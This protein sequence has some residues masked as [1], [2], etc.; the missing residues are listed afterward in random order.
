MYTKEIKKIN[1]KSI[2]LKKKILKK[3]I[4][5]KQN[6]GI[7]ESILESIPK[8]QQSIQQQNIKNIFKKPDNIDL[9]MFEKL[10]G[11]FCKPYKKNTKFT[12][13]MLK[14]DNKEQ[15]PI[16][17]FNVNSKSKNLLN[18]LPNL[19]DVILETYYYIHSNKYKNIIIS[20][21][22]DSNKPNNSL[23]QEILGLKSK[24]NKEIL[25]IK[26][27]DMSQL[28]MQLYQFRYYLHTYKESL[29]VERYYFL[30]FQ[31][32]KKY[33]NEFN[34]KLVKMI[35]YIEYIIKILRERYCIYTI[36]LIIYFKL[37]GIEEISVVDLL[38]KNYFYTYNINQN[39]IAKYFTQANSKILLLNSYNIESLI[40][41]FDVKGYS[42]LNL[43]TQIIKTVPNTSNQKNT[44]TVSNIAKITKYNMLNESVFNYIN[45]ISK[46]ISI[47]TYKS[48][49]TKP[50]YIS[51]F[52]NFNENIKKKIFSNIP[53]NMFS[54]SRNINYI[55]N[56]MN[57]KNTKNTKK[58][59]TCSCP[60]SC[61]SVLTSS[62]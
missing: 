33:L 35:S 38:K 12:N 56:T 34:N 28:I 27:Y 23:Y 62:N 53:E 46:N 30:M 48:I 19:D 26:L 21:L 20:I 52:E 14:K 10:I 18:K 61:N 13:K 42:L 43:I 22:N 51:E 25:L 3:S 60:C 39:I 5:L 17:K 8:T 2:P 15:E 9:D 29:T 59:C 6:G 54:N 36:Y 31:D 50:Y 37:E 7:N 55:K 40:Y 41:N 45:K 4:N 47:I 32:K 57:T 49:L 58:N 11:S 44:N 24:Q 1:T 16:I